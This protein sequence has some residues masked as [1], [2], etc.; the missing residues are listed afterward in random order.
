MDHYPEQAKKA[1]I[2]VVTYKEVTQ[3]RDA[4]AYRNIDSHELSGRTAGEDIPEDR[5]I[6]ATSII[7]AGI[8]IPGRRMLISS[9]EMLAN[10]EGSL[11]RVA[12]DAITEKQLEGRVGR[13]QSGDIVVRPTSAGTGPRPKPYS[14]PGYFASKLYSETVNVLQLFAITNEGYYSMPE[15]PGVSFKQSDN[16]RMDRSLALLVYLSY[17]GVE[18][19]N[20]KEV[21]HKSLAGN[22][23]EEYENAL[24]FILRHAVPK[25]THFD[26]ILAEMTARTI[27]Y[28]FMKNRNDQLAPAGSLVKWP[29]C[30][31]SHG[32]F[33]IGTCIAVSSTRPLHP[34][35]GRWQSIGNVRDK[36][37]VV[38][39]VTLPGQSMSMIYEDMLQGYK[40]EK[41]RL[42]HKVE[43]IF[44][45]KDPL[46]MKKQLRSLVKRET[47]GKAA[48]PDHRVRPLNA[49]DEKNVTF[50]M[51]ANSEIKA[52]QLSG[53]CRICGQVDA[54]HIHLEE[55]LEEVPWIP[56]LTKEWV[57]IPDSGTGQIEIVPEEEE[58]VLE[59]D[60]LP[61]VAIVKDVEHKR[62]YNR[63]G[64]YRRRFTLPPGPCAIDAL[65]PSTKLTWNDF[66]DY[67]GAERY[68]QG[69][70]ESDELSLFFANKGYNFS[71]FQ[72][73]ENRLM[74]VG[75]SDPHKPTIL[76]TFVGSVEEGHWTQGEVIQPLQPSDV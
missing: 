40:E 69:W 21:Y 16:T 73:G 39:S 15:M 28:T 11:Q 26:A 56:H 61:D 13:Y 32:S 60:K 41:N 64:G 44:K 34:I 48:K 51:G 65:P 30:V 31:D 2:R 24:S 57:Y 19:R 23:P 33:L 67:F 29:G 4:L 43:E 8:S 76:Y 12:T 62:A 52:R 70:F 20:L 7:D 45:I 71:V 22:V 50:T 9:G 74:A 5:V 37:T 1:I 27:V 38:P 54:Q 17:L 47:K 25:D 75:P 35:S 53:A 63:G 66:A 58:V 68:T 3:V 49:Y 55:D 10:M 72:E 59:E 42:L 46:E 36:M 6:V 18:D 14:A